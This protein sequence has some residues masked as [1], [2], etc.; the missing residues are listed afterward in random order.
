MTCYPPTVFLTNYARTYEI[1]I[2]GDGVCVY[3]KWPPSRGGKFLQG[4]SN[5]CDA[6]FKI[7]YKIWSTQRWSNK[8]QFHIGSNVVVIYDLFHYLEV[9]VVYTHS[10]ASSKQKYKYSDINRKIIEERESLSIIEATTG[11]KIL[12]S[13]QLGPLHTQD[14]EP[15]TITLQALSLVEKAELV[16]VCFTI[17]LRDQHSKWM[18]YG[19]KVYMESYMTSNG[20][21]FMVTWIIFKNHLLEVGLTQNTM[22]KAL[23]TL[24]TVDLFYFIMCETRMNEIHWYSIWLKAQSHMAS[25][26][27]EGPR[28][29]YMILDVSWDNLWTLSFG[30]SRFHGHGSW[31]VC[32]VALSEVSIQLDQHKSLGTCFR[33]SALH[34]T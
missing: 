9:G 8:S 16:Q 7:V 19:C 31:L 27:L 34:L 17:R 13:K 14:W 22:T 1:V 15:V 33:S 4:R 25:P 10:P 5:S 23:W 3:S 32:E 2:G 26:T 18:Q 30:L 6:C 11:P 28:P 12:D 20:S 24:T 21:C 29:H